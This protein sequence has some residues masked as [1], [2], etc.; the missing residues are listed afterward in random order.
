ML[1]ST[2]QC[3]NR[4]TIGRIFLSTLLWYTSVTICDYGS[5]YGSTTKKLEISGTAETS[6]DINYKL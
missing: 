6:V 1:P 5:N 2:V 3:L 4:D